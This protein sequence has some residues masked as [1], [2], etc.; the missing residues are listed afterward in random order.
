MKVIL[1]KRFCGPFKPHYIQID[2]IDIIQQM[3]RC[4]FSD[5]ILFLDI[6]QSI[7]TPALHGHRTCQ[8]T[9]QNIL[10]ILFSVTFKSHSSEGL[11]P[12]LTFYCI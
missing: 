1:I 7:S 2:I 12:S 8:L 4:K 6:L 9:C 5:T 10:E 3:D 11:P